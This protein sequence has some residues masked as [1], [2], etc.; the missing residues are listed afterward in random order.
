MID[1]DRLQKIADSAAAFE[2]EHGSLDLIGHAPMDAAAHRA[3]QRRRREA[4]R[5]LRR[6]RRARRRVLRRIARRT[7]VIRAWISW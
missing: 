7:K 1:Q 3:L 6:Q 2:D 5:A 4:H